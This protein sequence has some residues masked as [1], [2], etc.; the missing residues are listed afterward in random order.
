M[1]CRRCGENIGTRASSYG[2]ETSRQMIAAP[3]VTKHSN[4]IVRVAVLLMLAATLVA[5][6][7]P[8]NPNPRNE[9]DW[10][11]G[12]NGLH[13]GPFGLA[14][15]T[16]EFGRIDPPAPPA[17]SLELWLE[18]G[19]V[20]ESTAILDFYHLPDLTDFSVRQEAEGLYVLLGVP[21]DRTYRKKEGIWVEWAFVVGK[22]THLVINSGGDGASVFIDGRQVGHAPH[23]GLTP[24]SISGKLVVGDSTVRNNAWLGVM[25]GLA[26][27]DRELTV[28]EINVDY[29]SWLKNAETRDE[30]ARALGL[31]TFGE[32]AGNIVHNRV[33]G[34]D[35][36]IPPH[37]AVVK[38]SFLTPPWDEFYPAWEYVK[39]LIVNVVGFMPLG[40]LLC[41]YLSVVRKW[42]HSISK[43]MFICA[44]ISLVIE[45]LQGFLPTRTSGL[46]D[47]IT[48]ATGGLLGAALFHLRLTR[49]IF[50]RLGLEE[51]EPAE[52]ALLQRAEK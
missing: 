42:D 13:F 16:G 20:A 8:F 52:K 30:H 2:D 26:F 23:F 12:S 39:D 40:F 14:L 6:L 18:P 49:A 17:C 24:D 1:V 22:R 51:A 7:W 33:R 48:N 21:E 46:T 4:S 34:P 5:T 50:E 31:Y 9:V 43:T 32:R 29:S 10:I 41:A 11:E 35:L 25:R 44:G 3:V 45:T 27:Y 36:F 38:H 47:V 15:S 37:Y 28:P 19:T